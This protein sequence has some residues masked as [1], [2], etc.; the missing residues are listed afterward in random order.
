LSYVL[1]IRKIEDENGVKFILNERTICHNEETMKE[2]NKIVKEY[3]EIKA[4]MNETISSL[5]EE[6][7]AELKTI[8]QGF[9]TSD[10]LYEWIKN[11]S[12]NLYKRYFKK[13][14]NSEGV[15]TF[16]VGSRII[17][18][19]TMKKLERII[20]EY[21]IKKTSRATVQ[22]YYASRATVQ[23]YYASRMGLS[24]NGGK[25]KTNRRKRGKKTRRRTSK[26]C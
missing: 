9:T 2:L 1:F 21:Y 6:L 25:R 15:V 17:D 16:Q 22:E 5:E 11:S 14:I 24:R 10:I 3:Y 23:E 8:L 26:R 20:E 12:I 18:E 4:F 19:E 7:N 13:S